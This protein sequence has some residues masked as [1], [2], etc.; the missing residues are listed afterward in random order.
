MAP[1]IAVRAALTDGSARAL[2]LREMRLHKGR[3]LIRLDGVDDANAAQP[4]VGATLYVARAD[5]TMAADEYFDEDL[6]GCVLV[7]AADGREL[8]VVAAVEH[9]PAQDMLRVASGAFVPLVREFVEGVDVAG[10][11]IVVALPAGLLEGEAE[12]DAGR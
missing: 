4:L 11:R 6:V 5:V 10:K 12:V 8:G 1:G 7:D 3:P 9:F 2:T